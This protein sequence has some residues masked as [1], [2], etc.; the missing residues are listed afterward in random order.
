MIE[1]FASIKFDAVR[2]AFDCSEFD[3][4]AIGENAELFIEHFRSMKDALAEKFSELLVNKKKIFQID[5]IDSEMS[6][7]LK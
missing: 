2:K 5:D 7:E 4:S 6:E 3:H 1:C